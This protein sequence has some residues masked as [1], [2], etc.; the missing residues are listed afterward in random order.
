MIISQVGMSVIYGVTYRGNPNLMN[1]GAIVNVIA[2][3]ILVV[4]G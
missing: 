4:S 1:V 3:A 2:L